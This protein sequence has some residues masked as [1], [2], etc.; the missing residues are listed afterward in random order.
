MVATLIMLS[1]V[2]FMVVAF[3]GVA[4]RERRQLEVVTNMDAARMAN[5]AGRSRAIAEVLARLLATGDKY[6]Y[7]VM[8][9]TNFQSPGFNPLVA[10]P[11]NVN[12][13]NALALPGQPT[14]WLANL[15]NLQ[16]DPRLPVFSPYYA[17]VTPYDPL[18]SETNQGRWYLDFNHGGLF[19]YTD[20]FQAGDPHWIGMLEYP[21]A[22]HSANN[23]GIARYAYLVMPAGKAV[24]LNWIHNQAKLS[25][26]PAPA[27][28]T[29]EGYLRNLGLGPHEMNLA[30]MLAEANPFWNYNYNVG[31]GISGGAPSTRDVFRD[32]LDLLL[33]RNNGGYNNLAT[34]TALFGAVPSA[35][36][37][38]AQ[39][40][41]LT[42]G[43]L[44]LS[45]NLTIDN[46]LN[47]VPWAGGS[48][49]S[50]LAQRYFDANELFLPGRTYSS[51]F[52]TNLQYITTNNL[53]PYDPAAPT[54][55]GFIGNRD[56]RVLY[57]LL[58]T[59]GTDSWPVN[60][61]LNINWSNAVYNPSSIQIGSSGGELSG[62]ASWDPNYF[63]FNAAELMI[64]ASCTPV[65]YYDSTLNP[66]NWLATNWFFGT[67][68]ANI[69]NLPASALPTFVP[70]RG[71]T[72]S[73]TN[74]PIHP[75]S[76][77]S[78][79]M[80]RILQ[81]AA[82][83]YD[84]TT[85]NNGSPAY[86][87]LFRPLFS[88]YTNGWPSNDFVY[89]SGY[90]TNQT[91]TALLGLPMFDLS[92]P[93]GRLAMYTNGG[94]VVAA[95][96][97]GNHPT[98][99]IAGTP[100]IVGARRGYPN[101]NEFGMQTIFSDTRRLEF[102]KTNATNFG[103][104][105]IVM[106]NQSIIIGLTNIYGFEAWNSYYTAF[107]RDLR[108][109]ATNIAYV[110]LT[111]EFGPVYT[112]ISTNGILTNILAN[113]WKGTSN[114]LASFKG[115]FFTNTP[116]LTTN[117]AR[118]GYAY[119]TNFPPMS[120]FTNGGFIAAAGQGSSAGFSRSNGFP[121]MHL[122]ITITN[123]ITYAL[124]E[125]ASNKVVDFATLTNLITG[126]N[127]ST[128]LITTNSQNPNADPGVRFWL[129][130][131]VGGA[132]AMNPTI[133]ITNQIAM[134]LDTNVN[135]NTTNLWRQ[136]SMTTPTLR[137]IDRFRR[138]LGTNTA[139]PI[140]Q[141][142]SPGSS[143]QSP[144]NPTRVITFNTT[145]EV[146][147]PLVH[148][149]TR[150]LMD[151]FRT[152]ISDQIMPLQLPINYPIPPPGSL[153]RVD[154]GFVNN[155]LA[156]TTNGGVN[157]YYLPW[158]QALKTIGTSL[159][160]YT[161]SNGSI[162]NF[163]LVAPAA[164]DQRLKDAG[165]YSS[166]A[167]DFPQRKFA[168]LGW[169][170]R[171]HRGTP[172]QTV[173]LKSDIPN[174]TNWFYWAHSADTSPTNDWRLMDVFSTAINADA[175]RSLLSINQ[176]NSAAWAAALGGVLVLSNNGVSILPMT[177]TPQTP[178]L[179]YLVGGA[180]NGIINAKQRIP[181][182][183]PVANYS[184]GDVVSYFN[185]PY[186]FVNYYMA[187]VSTNQNQNPFVQVS[188]SNQF[189]YWTNVNTWN[190]A[191]TYGA[192]DIVAYYGVS[193]YSIQGGNN[194]RPPDVNTDWWEPYQYR[195]FTRLGQILSTPE[196]SVQS[197]YLNAGVAWQ[198]GTAYAVG[199][200]VYWQGWYYQAVRPVPANTPPNPY[201]DYSTQR[202]LANS[203]W[204]PLE[205][206]V[207]AR[208]VP[209]SLTDAFIERIPQQT[210][211][212]L[213]LETSPRAKIYTW[214]QALRPADRGIYVG[215]APYQGMVTNYQITGE[216]ATLTVV[217]FDGLPEPGLLPR[218]IPAGAPPQV[219]PRVIVESHKQVP[220]AP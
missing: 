18:A 152:A 119:S 164:Y 156:F 45:T 162:T 143:I 51:S 149:T 151:P 175:T 205:S 212:M 163:Y 66:T 130:N 176:T 14:P 178:Q 49:S 86:P 138:F 28:P 24:D 39:Y 55:P 114:G 22:P 154:F 194:N 145:W 136:F 84:A 87:T 110:V 91:D 195:S 131:R 204:W 160:N 40:D 199:A 41:V 161:N 181:K 4:R 23:R 113:T 184:Q 89:I 97:K 112:N 8:V 42:T 193:Y 78:G 7:G 43:P 219:L 12:H 57:T 6:N 26:L 220:A 83:V 118:F 63:F 218:P 54:V 137:E 15:A 30:A 140:N 129:T 115:F 101:F 135:A 183:Q 76:Y 58:S 167:W 157:R 34:L 62:F 192:G 103:P 120:G 201:L 100:V 146:N 72:L 77:Y 134:C 209:E 210:L 153:F 60:G 79:E 159:A 35:N 191:T 71:I 125:P 217:R 106:T 90:T 139:L 198:L 108:L 65:V 11:N 169:L 202:T 92:D 3:L 13:T 61:K 123:T 107:P 74:I 109:V 88:F 196:L 31:A 56:R 68:Y 179:S 50:T 46:D 148:Y 215:G 33:F 75:Y 5:E 150:D 121:A 85:T 10:S 206:P 144:F 172:W 185:G 37:V 155:R 174:P 147:D 70:N 127:L 80:H 211:G 19:D 27:S 187:T 177:I 200:R 47:N 38:S 141:V 59:L 132:S 20:R 208:Q 216:S 124:Y 180:T 168:N 21:D 166:D 105:A 17:N 96:G 171:V 99:L 82:N 126:V 165:I 189:G 117:L 170:G 16:Y 81:L 207:L 36:L 142:P 203:Y 133:G 213:Q 214:G 67:S 188:I 29:A 94:A 95:T 1:L 128:A 190:G 98:C 25:V 122:G 52:A 53:T 73:V 48:N 9:S 173:Y 64:R 111:N 2:T 69:T 197:P 186:G 32:A 158:G 116:Q 93:N 102:V 104:N 182:W 44:M